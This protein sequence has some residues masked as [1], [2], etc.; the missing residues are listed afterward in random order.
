M[1]KGAPAAICAGDRLVGEN[2][3]MVGFTALM[4]ANKPMLGVDVDP[5]LDPEPVGDDTLIGP[6][7]APEGILTSRAFWVTGDVTLANGKIV[8][9]SFTT[10][11]DVLAVAP[12]LPAICSVAPTGPAEGVKFAI[13]KVVAG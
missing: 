7:L 10:T 5:V 11:F 2:D 4:T 13:T 12:K 1:T 9:F 3:V 6:V 8:P